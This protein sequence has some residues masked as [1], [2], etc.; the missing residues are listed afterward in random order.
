MSDLW[1]R[2]T[3]GVLGCGQWGFV[4]SGSKVP[5]VFRVK[6]GSSERQKVRDEG[7]KLDLSKHA[8]TDNIRLIL[9]YHRQRCKQFGHALDVH[10]LGVCV[11]VCDF[12]FV[13]QMI[14]PN[15]T[16]RR[17]LINSTNILSVKFMEY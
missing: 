1:T 2:E 13:L 10:F 8:L 3:T 17:E 15:T 6:D 5:G 14:G 9:Q 11:C 16:E 12:L 4:S 7:E